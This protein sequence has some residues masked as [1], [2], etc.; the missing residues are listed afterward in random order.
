MR[1]CRAIV[2][3]LVSG[4]FSLSAVIGLMSCGNSGGGAPAEVTEAHVVGKSKEEIGKYLIQV[5]G[6][7][8]CHTPGAKEGKLP[9]ESEWL[10]GS[11][12]GFNGPWGTTYAMNLR[13]KVQSFPSADMWV[14]SMK[15]RDTKPPMP[16]SALHAMTD[17]DLSSVYAYI[18]GLGPKGVPTPDA[19]PLGVEPSGPYIV[20][21]PPTVGQGATK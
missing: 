7:N 1:K 16:W 8:D 12:L 18:K 17:D 14:K 6:C 3:G 2:V 15:M 19:L 20:M 13:L 5:G 9:A 11:P 4:L 21:A 10:T